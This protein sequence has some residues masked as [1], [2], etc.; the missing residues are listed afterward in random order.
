MNEPALARVID[1]LTRSAPYN[2]IDEIRQQNQELLAT[3]EQLRQ[4]QDELSQLNAELEDTNRGVV[5][6]YAEL[7][8]K[9]DTLR[10]AD[11]LKS[12]FLSNMSHEFRTPL[13][14]ILALSRLL[15]EDRETPLAPGQQ[16]QVG[17]DDRAKGMALGADAY[18]LK[19]VGRGWLL[20]TLE[21]LVERRRVPRLL[22]IDDD[23]ISRYLV[24]AQIGDA[25]L[26]VQEATGGAD[27]LREARA[28]RP[29]AIVLDL[30]MPEMNGFEVMS[31]LKDDPAT[32][33][34]PVIVLT[35][36][37]LSE[38]ERRQLAPHALR[39]ISKETLGREGQASDLREALVAAGILGRIHG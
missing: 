18:A 28:Q 31:R 24:R 35:S 19:P 30:S 34:I 25:R 9:A 21:Q 23:E 29:Q 5:A 10:R 17:Y 33:D 6:L 37:T 16:R 3:L 15:L 1:R 22:V 4:R 27:G 20:D 11:E 39:I 2:P 14:S 7:D 32:T 36:M 26:T 38:D 8:E 13:N 12:R